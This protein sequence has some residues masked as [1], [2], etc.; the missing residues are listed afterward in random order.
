MTSAAAI[1][2]FMSR[3][4]LTPYEASSVPTGDKAPAFPYLTYSVAS[5]YWESGET[6]LTVDLW[7]RCTSNTE[8]NAK[9]DAIC[10]AIGLGGVLLHSDSGVIWVKRG[11][12]FCQ[13]MGDQNDA[14]VKR[15]HINLI[16]EYHTTH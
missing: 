13:S 10:E 5:G 8:P 3:F 11:S 9:A 1:H 2:E 12:P 14:S 6:A 15:R 7:Y 16:T 4:G